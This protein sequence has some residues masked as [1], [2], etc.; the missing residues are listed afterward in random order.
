[1]IYL[2]IQQKTF[3]NVEITCLVCEHVG[4]KHTIV[5]KFDHHGENSQNTGCWDNNREVDKSRTGRIL[6]C[7]IPHKNPMVI[8]WGAFCIFT[9]IKESSDHG[10]LE[11]EHYQPLVPQCVCELSNFKLSTV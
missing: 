7:S 5:V 3:E 11:K 2:S 8:S 6:T 9:E 1:M 10:K 4:Q